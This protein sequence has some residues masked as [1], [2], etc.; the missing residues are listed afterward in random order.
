V[1]GNGALFRRE[2][3]SQTEEA[4]E[5]FHAVATVNDE[6][7]EYMQ[8][9]EA[10]PFFRTDGLDEKYKLLAEFGDCVLAGRQMEKD[11]GM[12]FVCWQRNYDRSG[13]CHGHYHYDDYSAAKEDFAIRSGLVARERVFSQD[14]LTEIYR[15]LSNTLDC[16][17]YLTYDQ[18]RCLE[19]LQ[20]KI[21]RQVPDIAESLES[22]MEQTL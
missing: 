22:G 3:D 13:V 19:R 8:A 4:N 11:Y 7:M 10:M 16:G 17:D 12:E 15:S 21:E 2:G 1:D 9:L 20:Q 5:V 18:E 6:V 14:E